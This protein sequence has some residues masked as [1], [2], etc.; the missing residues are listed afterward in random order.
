[1]VLEGIVKLESP[2]YGGNHNEMHL[3]RGVQLSLDTFEKGDS[4]LFCKGS[5]GRKGYCMTCNAENDRYYFI[6]PTGAGRVMR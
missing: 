5:S 1:M 6:S 2:V 3:L 4:K